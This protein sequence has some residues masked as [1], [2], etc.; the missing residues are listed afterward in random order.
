[1]SLAK[2]TLQ[3]S[4]SDQ[5]ITVVLTPPANKAV[6][7]DHIYMSMGVSASKMGL[8]QI[9]YPSVVSF[10]ILADWLT[11]DLEFPRGLSSPNNAVV[12][13]TLNH[14]GNDFTAHKKLTVVYHHDIE[15]T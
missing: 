10:E 15:E 13:V 11:T 5:P 14:S 6:Y 7:I 4:R 2:T 3:S 8:I 12:T 1:M 9:S